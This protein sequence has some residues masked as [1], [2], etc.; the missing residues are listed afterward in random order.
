MIETNPAERRLRCGEALSAC[1]IG[2]VQ[3]HS[4]TFG[5][6]DCL[7]FDF[8]HRIFAVSDASERCP[9]ASRRLLQ[10]LA[11]GA[12]RMPWPGCLEAAWCTQPY[13]QK[14]TCIGVH[15][16]MDPTPHAVIVA[17]GDSLIWI[18]DCDNGKILFRNTPDMHVAG[19]MSAMPEERRVLLTSGS[20]I[21]LASDGIMDVF[22]RNG[23]DGAMVSGLGVDA[24]P[25]D[26]IGNIRKL[27]RQKQCESLAH[28]DIAVLVIDPF[29]ELATC[30]R[31]VILGGTSPHEEAQFAGSSLPEAWMPIGE[32][33]KNGWSTTMGMS[34]YDFSDCLD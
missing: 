13:V 5:N 20:R 14:T 11:A 9:Q 30:R 22:E 3:R 8:G 7:L 26:W 24:A 32:A 12:S 21:V 27:V 25:M 18:V 23:D 10:A 31:T 2:K 33:E 17:G 1:L 6:G 29:K 15:I 28:D 19:G 4:E 34:F 16:E